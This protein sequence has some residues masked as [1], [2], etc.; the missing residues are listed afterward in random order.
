[1]LW[2]QTYWVSGGIIP[3]FFTS[4]L[5][6]AEWSASYNGHLTPGVR[7][8]GTHW[9]GGWVSPRDRL[10]RREKILSFPLLGTEPVIQPVA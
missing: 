10:D 6:G 2:R 1:M 3:H 7:A 4:A 9:T 8:P 5:D